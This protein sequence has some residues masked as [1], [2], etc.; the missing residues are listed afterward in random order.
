M[1]ATRPLFGRMILKRSPL[2]EK[3][4]HPDLQPHISGVESRNQCFVINQH[5]MIPE[6]ECVCSVCVFMG[7]ENVPVNEEL[8][9]LMEANKQ[10]SKRSTKNI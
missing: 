4:V 9:N 3:P 10:S 7:S 6:E 2:G 8:R 5:F 1:A